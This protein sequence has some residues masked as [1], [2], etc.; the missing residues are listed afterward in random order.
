[1]SQSV[2]ERLSDLRLKIKLFDLDATIS[3]YPERVPE[4]LSNR[5]FTI[6]NTELKKFGD[7]SKD[8]PF[9]VA[10]QTRKPPANPNFK[11]PRQIF[12][13]ATIDQIETIVNMLIRREQ[14]GE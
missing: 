11:R 12:R 7:P 8:H 5:A 6:E 3:H 4:K 9:A 14:C 10:F 2:E 13:V 1:V